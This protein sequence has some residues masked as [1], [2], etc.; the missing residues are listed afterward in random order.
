M[1][2]ID[3]SSFCLHQESLLAAALLISCDRVS[4]NVLHFLYAV[5]YT[6]IS[7]IDIKQ[8]LLYLR[9]PVSSGRKKL[10]ERL[11]VS[12][13]SE[14]CNVHRNQLLRIF[15]DKL[16]MGPQEY[17]IKYRMSKGAQL[18]LTT[19]LTVKEISSAVGYENQLHFSRAFKKVYGISPVN[20]RKEYTG[21]AVNVDSRGLL[22]TGRR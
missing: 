4:H 16:G 12:S 11:S 20:F 9:L 18:L 17:L 22:S 1:I 14:K 10:Y 5:I 19:K 8:R 7:S 15:K 13:I 6:C 3:F 2:L 21:Y